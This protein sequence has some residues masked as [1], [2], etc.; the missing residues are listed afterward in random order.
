MMDSS[1][2]PFC[3]CEE[4]V[5][6]FTARN[7]RGLRKSRP[8]SNS[9]KTDVDLITCPICVY[10]LFSAFLA[11]HGVMPPPSHSLPPGWLNESRKWRGPLTA[12]CC[13]RSRASPLRCTAAL[14]W[15]TPPKPS[16]MFS[17]FCW[18]LLPSAELPINGCCR[19]QW[20]CFHKP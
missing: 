3:I 18:T 4:A 1:G 20:K 8:L 19:H 14:A 5:F 7:Q 12:A 13:W 15:R 10:A 16:A 6:S 11:L 17:S 2:P 9:S